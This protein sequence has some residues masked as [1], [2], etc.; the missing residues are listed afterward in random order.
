ML[1]DTHLMII[2]INYRRDT[3]QQ[4]QRGV[5]VENFADIDPSVSI[6]LGQK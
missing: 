5:L 4:S 2:K 3:K 1:N 6:F